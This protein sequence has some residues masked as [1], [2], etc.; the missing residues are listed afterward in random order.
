MTA[1]VR[2]TPYF[3]SYSS[4]FS[5]VLVLTLMATLSGAALYRTRD[6][7]VIEALD[8]PPVDGVT[9]PLLRMEKAL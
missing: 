8:S 6:Y 9:V 3:D 2:I 5:Y 4:T 1:A 7:R